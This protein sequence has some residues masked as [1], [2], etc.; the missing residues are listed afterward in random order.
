[1]GH[2]GHFTT[3]TNCDLELWLSPQELSMSCSEVSGVPCSGTEPA[4]GAFP[5]PEQTFPQNTDTE[6]PEMLQGKGTAPNC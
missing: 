2:Q 1:M 6:C 4:V 5:T 3:D